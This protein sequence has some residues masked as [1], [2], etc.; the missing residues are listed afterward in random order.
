MKKIGLTWICLNFFYFLFT[1]PGSV[2]QFDKF[3]FTSDFCTVS[4]FVFRDSNLFPLIHNT[5]HIKFVR[6]HPKTIEISHSLF[7]FSYVDFRNFHHH[8][9][10]MFNFKATFPYAIRMISSIIAGICNLKNMKNSIFW[11]IK[12]HEY[13]KTTVFSEKSFIRQ[14]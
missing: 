6:K 1:A 11:E 4:I 8:G 3:S 9:K 2:D 13:H 12:C 7:S 5:Q 10:K 14:V